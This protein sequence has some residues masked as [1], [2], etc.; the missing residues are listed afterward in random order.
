MCLG[1]LPVQLQCGLTIEL[2]CK[3]DLQVQIQM[4]H[5]YLI[6]LG[7]GMRVGG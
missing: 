7:I 3:V 1:I 4:R 6:W 2:L 5:A